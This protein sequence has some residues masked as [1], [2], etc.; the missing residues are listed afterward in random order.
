MQNQSERCDHCGSEIRDAKSAVQREGKTYCSDA[1]A[2]Q[3]AQRSQ[4]P[5][6]TPIT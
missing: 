3:G 1:C 6:K 4:Q 2:T 5:S